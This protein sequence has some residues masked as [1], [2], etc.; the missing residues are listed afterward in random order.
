[1]LFK[2]RKQ[3]NLPC[4]MFPEVYN[5]IAKQTHVLIAG[6]SGSGKSVVINGI[7]YTLLSK[8]FPEECKIIL[9]DPKRVELAAW[10]NTRHCIA[11]ASEP[12]EPTQA[13][14][15]ALELT[16]KRYKIMQREGVK[17]Y[18]GGHI[19]I[20][21]DEL[22]DLMTTEKQTVTP[23]IQRLAQIGRAAN[24]H[25][26][27]ATQ[28]PLTEIIPTK[29]KVNFDCIIGLKTACKQHSRNI[30]GFPGCECLAPYGAGYIITPQQT[31]I[32][33]LPMIEE[34]ELNK[35]QEYWKT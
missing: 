28:C 26:I 4:A 20:I 35:I 34:G 2:K 14:S 19:Y 29:I 31:N 27:A 24:V 5:M 7:I 9:I 11:Y 18:P 3:E 21:I 10:K 12:G 6:K 22:A 30:T 8:F 1:M 25:I 13:L 23:L 17:K 32:Y 33:K 16:E 15:L